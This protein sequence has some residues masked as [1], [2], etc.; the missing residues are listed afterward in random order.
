MTDRHIPRHALL[1]TR[2]LFVDQNRRIRTP[3]R[4]QQRAE[5][6]QLRTYILE[7]ANNA[8]DVAA[9]GAFN[10]L[11]YVLTIEFMNGKTEQ[12]RVIGIQ[13]LCRELEHFVPRLNR[14]H[15]LWFEVLD[16]CIQN[17]HRPLHGFFDNGLFN[18]FDHGLFNLFN[19]FNLFKVVLTNRRLKSYA[20]G[21]RHRRRFCE[22]INA[23]LHDQLHLDHFHLD[24]LHLDLLETVTSVL[25]EA[26]ASLSD[27]ALPRGSPTYLCQQIPIAR[28]TGILN[29]L[30]DNLDNL[31]INLKIKRNV[32]QVLD[33]I[34]NYGNREATVQ[35]AVQT[36]YQPLRQ[37]YNVSAANLPGLREHY[38]WR[39]NETTLMDLQFMCHKALARV[40]HRLRVRLKLEDL[41]DIV[42]QLQYYQGNRFC[43]KGVANSW[44]VY[45]P[46]QD[47]QP[48]VRG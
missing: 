4:A 38:V 22:M 20:L 18:L 35:T 36:A 42:P 10:T 17:L 23:I 28:Y 19:L 1:I 39:G 9:L 15:V 41:G 45:R 16:F 13:T 27:R 33:R 32:Y 46:P 29:I 40:L 6:D 2:W 7:I 37:A 8:Y 44:Q 30:N 12:H 25:A 48:Q 5:P 21:S 14:E 24:Q 47:N 34:V 31:E 43:K 11:E 26:A 3:E